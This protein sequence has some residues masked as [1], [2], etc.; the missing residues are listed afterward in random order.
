MGNKLS[1]VQCGAMMERLRCL[2]QTARETSL[3]QWLQRELEGYHEMDALPWYRIVECR[4]RGLFLH[5]HSGHQQTCQIHDKALGQ[6]DLN[7]LKFLLLR[8]SL[9]S[10]VECHTLELERWPDEILAAY[11]Q[12]LIPGH[13]CLHAWREPLVP[14]REQLIRGVDLMLQEY[15]PAMRREMCECNLSLRAIQHRRW[16][17]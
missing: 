8:G 2:Y 3:K 7:Q 15:V 5:T 11:S 6:R 13:V 1:T 14:V 9:D 4:Q 10:Y 17:I 12:Q 16:H